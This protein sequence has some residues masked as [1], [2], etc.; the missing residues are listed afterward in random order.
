MKVITMNNVSVKL[1]VDQLDAHAWE[2]VNNLTT[3]PFLFHHLALMPDARSTSCGISST[4]R[5]V[6]TAHIPQPISTP[7]A[8]GITTP[9]VAS[10]PPIGIRLRKNIAHLHAN[11]CNINLKDIEI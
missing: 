9:F 2:E 6:F 8:L 5:F 7:T 4:R 10:T 1:W 11:L 3:L